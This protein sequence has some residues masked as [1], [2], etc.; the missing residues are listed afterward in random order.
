MSTSRP[1]ALVHQNDLHVMLRP[2]EIGHLLLPSCIHKLPIGRDGGMAE[3]ACSWKSLARVWLVM[4]I[5]M[6]LVEMHRWCLRC[7]QAVE[8]HAKCVTRTN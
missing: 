7:S 8:M 5:K 4:S 1:L 2:P 3:A 6:Q